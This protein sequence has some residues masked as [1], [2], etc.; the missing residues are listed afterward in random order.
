MR[1]LLFR[2]GG[3]TLLGLGAIW[4]SQHPGTVTFLWQG[5]EMQV[6]IILFF[7][8]FALVLFFCIGLILLLRWVARWPE[9]YKQK[10]QSRQQQE[11]TQ[12]VA[13]YLM[14]LSGGR[15]GEAQRAALK[16]RRAMP[17]A[18]LSLM[19]GAQMARRGGN[20]EEEETYYRRMVEQTLFADAHQTNIMGLR[21]LLGLAVKKGNMQDIRTHAE[22]ALEIEQK[23]DWA[24]EALFNLEA[25]NGEWTKARHWLGQMG[26][27]GF[28]E[29]PEQNRRMAVLLMAEAETLGKN[30]RV[31]DRKTAMSNILQ[32]FKLAPDFV[33]SYK[34][35][36]TYLAGGGVVE[37]RKLAHQIEKAWKR[38]PHPE[39]VEAYQ[40]LYP[41]RSAVQ[42]LKAVQKL[43][44]PKP[45]HH[46]SL[47]ALAGAAIKAKRW[48]LAR[49]TLENEL[50]QQLAPALRERRFY[51]LMAELESGE[52]GD[53]ARARDWR[54]K[55]LSAPL[56][57]GW[58][59]PTGER[60]SWRAVCMKTGAFDAYEW[61][62]IAPVMGSNNTA[63]AMTVQDY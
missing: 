56:E 10:Q 49:V 41:G 34:L 26:R 24:M 43:I 51:R 5:Y 61:R 2:L 21:G 12:A 9:R 30:E 57:A 40:A 55:A 42:K 3:M 63:T 23:T 8:L 6:P 19:L 32:T 16:A 4:L 45:R 59:S 27:Y 18:G 7:I 46:E 58:F 38:C 22:R 50:A 47:Y 36:A 53:E 14:A 39:L 52:N 13:A 17:K 15:E 28:A 29:K 37:K 48:N 35:A 44:G 31:E 20:L 11:A 25:Q 62:K 1:R 54:D 60:G 33:P